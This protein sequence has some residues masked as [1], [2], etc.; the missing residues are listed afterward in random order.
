MKW[1][2][3]EMEELLCGLQRESR[4]TRRDDWTSAANV[5][6]ET[7]KRELG[8][9]P[10]GKVVKETWQWNEE[11]QECKQIKRLAQRKWD[12]HAREDSA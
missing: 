8:V 5:L 1:W 6:K 3:P 7:E 9:P 11:V 4:W 12:F 2:K 10:G